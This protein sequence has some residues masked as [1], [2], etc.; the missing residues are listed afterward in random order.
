MLVEGVAP[1]LQ[2]EAVVGICLRDF[3]GAAMMAAD[4]N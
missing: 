2:L 4:F 1:G 3:A